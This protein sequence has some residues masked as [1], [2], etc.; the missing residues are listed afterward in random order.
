M[1][2]KSFTQ[3]STAMKRTAATL[4]IAGPIAGSFIAMSTDSNMN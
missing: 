3:P 1:N 2:Y 4:E